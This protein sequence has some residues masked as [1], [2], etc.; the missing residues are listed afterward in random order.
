MRLAQ[1]V[2]GIVVNV[3]EVDPS[4]IPDFMADWVETETAGPGWTWTAEVGLAPPEEVEPPPVVP[5]RVSRL[6]AR[7]ALLGAGLLQN[8]EDYVAASDDIVLR[9]VWAEATEW[10]R[11]SPMI[12]T[13]AS[14]LSLSE[15]QVD[16]LFIA[17]GAITV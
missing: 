6:Q 5:E 3:A 10:H 9:M 13:I 8:V 7:L 1:I 4:A 11:G 14:A 15:S 17:A 12:A 2:N 16:N